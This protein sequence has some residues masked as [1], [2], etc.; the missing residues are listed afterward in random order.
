MQKHSVENAAGSSAPQSEDRNALLNDRSTL[1]NRH[2]L[3]RTGLFGTKRQPKISINVK[4]R[5]PVEC[6]YVEKFTVLEVYCFAAAA[7]IACDF[8]MHE[9]RRISKWAAES[10]KCIF[11][12]VCFMTLPDFERVEKLLRFGSIICGLTLIPRLHLA[13]TAVS[14]PSPDYTCSG[15][16]G[17]LNIFDPMYMVVSGPFFHRVQPLNIVSIVFC[18]F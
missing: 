4:T 9:S 7:P 1:P 18:L 17:L 10:A 8:M 13:R 14:L 15:V 2:L 12:C 6:Q 11:S 5:S 3:V 16:F